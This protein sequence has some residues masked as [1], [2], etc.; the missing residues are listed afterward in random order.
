MFKR[1]GNGSKLP[2]SPTAIQFTPYEAETPNAA[3]ASATAARVN[4]CRTSVQTRW[5]KRDSPPTE[6]KFFQLER[7]ASFDPVRYLEMQATGGELHLNILSKSGATDGRT[8]E[9]S[10]C[11]YLLR[12]GEMEEKVGE[13]TVGIV[14]TSGSA[15]RWHFRPRAEG[16]SAGGG[17]DGL[18]QP[19]TFGQ[20]QVSM[21]DAPQLQA[22]AVRIRSLPARR[23]GAAGEGGGTQSEILSAQSTEGG[24]LLTLSVLKVGADQLQ[25]NVDGNG[26]VKINGVDR[27]VNLFERLNNLSPLGALLFGVLNTAFLEGIRRFIFSKPNTEEQ[28]TAGA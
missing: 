8:A 21:D 22:R 13:V 23:S 10:G 9:Q 4:P 3:P 15:F 7:P 6:L 24:P 25:L 12:A 1:Y 27:S 19:F 26:W 5:E 16:T 17:A 20:S 2:T 11:V 28:P 14:A 18:S